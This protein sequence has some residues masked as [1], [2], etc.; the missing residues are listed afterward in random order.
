MCALVGLIS[1]ISLRGVAGIPGNGS[2]VDVMNLRM[3]WTWGVDIVDCCGSSRCNGASCASGAKG[4][5]WSCIIEDDSS[6]GLAG[7]CI[8]P[9]V[10]IYCCCSCILSLDS[11]D[12]RPFIMDGIG[13]W[14]WGT[15]TGGWMCT[16]ESNQTFTTRLVRE[17][18][19]ETYIMTNWLTWISS[20]TV[21]Q[22]FVISRLDKMI[23]LGRI[24]KKENICNL[25]ILF[26]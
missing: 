25:L 18:M 17:I 20:A 24:L 23:S 19:N 2:T 7:G 3:S 22:R 16:C 12:C 10:C 4:W 8:R 13:C 14:A 5:W 1:M 11:D 21:V 9:F 15:L 6:I 26:S